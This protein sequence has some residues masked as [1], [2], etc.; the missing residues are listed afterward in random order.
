MTDI[1]LEE[2]QKLLAKYKE[3]KNHGVVMV[4]RNSLHS[5]DIYAAFTLEELMRLSKIIE[6][7]K[8]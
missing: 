3:A 1:L 4:D 5:K 2:D 7:D 6:N 8:L